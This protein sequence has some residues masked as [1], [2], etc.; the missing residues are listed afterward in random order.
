M[1]CKVCKVKILGKNNQVKLEKPRRRG[2]F[3]PSSGI[4]RACPTC[5]MLYW[6]NGPKVMRAI[7]DGKEVTGPVYLLEDGT[8]TLNP[9]VAAKP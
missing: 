1:Y 6:D 8:I 9:G 3:D 5:G 7:I 2:P 4:A